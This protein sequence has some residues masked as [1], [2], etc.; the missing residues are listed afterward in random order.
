MAHSYRQG[1]LTGCAQEFAT[2][3]H[4][5]HLNP[6]ISIDKF[7]NLDLRKNFFKKIYGE[8][9]YYNRC[10]YIGLVGRRGGKFA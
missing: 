6:L 1:L 3:L 5:F 8:G 2:G 10:G 9:Y 4:G 7:Y